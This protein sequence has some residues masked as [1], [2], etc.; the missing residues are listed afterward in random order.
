[1]KPHLWSLPKKLLFIFGIWLIML[2]TVLIGSLIMAAI[3]EPKA[4]ADM[5]G[6]SALPGLSYLNPYIQGCRTYVPGLGG[7]APSIPMPAP[8]GP[9]AQYPWVVGVPTPPA[10]I[11][12][13][14]GIPGLPLNGPP[15]GI[16][17]P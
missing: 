3:M 14:P 5:C 1:M 13:P 2:A 9:V 15:A 6:P 17:T 8:V 11:Y 10:P 4:H 7:Y 16:N 12:Q